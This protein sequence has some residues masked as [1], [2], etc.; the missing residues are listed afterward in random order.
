MDKERVQFENI[1][2]KSFA[3]MLF[4][5]FLMMLTDITGCGMKSDFTL[6]QKDPGVKGLYIISAM[7]IINVLLQVTIFVIKKAFF[8]KIVFLVSVCY[9]LFFVAH[10]VIHLSSGEGI[11]IH[12]FLDLTHHIL[13]IFAVYYSYKWAKQKD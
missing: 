9:T 10:Q 4:L 6:L 12:F 13:G 1:I 11:D 5:L 3:G 7:A 8:R 2:S